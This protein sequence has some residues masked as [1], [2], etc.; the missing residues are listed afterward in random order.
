MQELK[1]SENGLKRLTLLEGNFLNAYLDIAGVW[2]IGVGHTGLVDGKVI[3][4][5]MEITA[6]KSLEL[7]K[8]DISEMSKAV[9]NLL[10]VEV[11]Q[12]EFDA[13]VIFTFNIGIGGFRNSTM[14]KLLNKNDRSEKLFTAWLMWTKITKAGQKVHSKGLLNRRNAEIKLFKNGYDKNV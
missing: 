4:E 7:L 14:L 1:F 12:N 2:T 9:N 13:L 10:K 8:Q 3:D 11:T 6:T 5:D